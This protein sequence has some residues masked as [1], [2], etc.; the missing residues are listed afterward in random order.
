MKSIIQTN[1]ECY[2]CKTTIGLEEH[3]CLYGNA[4][5]KAEQDG[6]K[7]WLCYE[8][9]RGDMG[10]HGKNGSDLS[11]YLKKISELKWLEYYDK[12]IDDF[13]KRYGK[14]YIS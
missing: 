7:V 3:H 2:V 11:N 8:H 13:I 12:D 10:V 4:R 1:K 5:K 6:L 9:H 14:N